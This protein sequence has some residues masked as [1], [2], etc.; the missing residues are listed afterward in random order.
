MI[1]LFIDRGHPGPNVFSYRKYK[2]FSCIKPFLDAGW[3]V[4]Y[5]PLLRE[6]PRLYSKILR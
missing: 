2:K 5:P 6:F 1:R 4:T 3:Q